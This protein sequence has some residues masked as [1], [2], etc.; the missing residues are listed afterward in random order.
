MSRFVASGLVVA[1]VLSVS[2]CRYLDHASDDQLRQRVHGV[3]PLI[4]TCRAM[5]ESA[6]LTAS[7]RLLLGDTLIWD[8]A[9][10]SR[11][12]ADDMLPNSVRR[13][14]GKT[15]TIFMILPAR[16]VAVGTYSVS[17]EVGYSRS[18]DVAVAYWPQKK[19][20]GMVT[21]SD[22]PPT[23][24]IVQFHPDYGDPNRA[25]AD[26]IKQYWWRLPGR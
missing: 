7:G 22:A 10:D 15:T 16:N 14:Q 26:W 13:G 4:D 3:A 5:G 2:A 9:S 20:R 11:S 23:S 21:F 24:R 18:V 17:G 25:I 12:K 6:M 1:S 19:A 8:V